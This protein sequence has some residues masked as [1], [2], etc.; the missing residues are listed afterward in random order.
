MSKAEGLYK[1]QLEDWSRTVSQMNEQVNAL[2]VLSSGSSSVS[3]T[4][5]PVSTSTQ[6]MSPRRTQP[7][8][9]SLSAGSGAT[10]TAASPMASRL[11]RSPVATSIP[12]SYPQSPSV[13]SP[14]PSRTMGRPGGMVFQTPHTAGTTSSRLHRPFSTPTTTTGNVTTP[15]KAGVTGNTSPLPTTAGSAAQ[16]NR[17][18]HTRHPPMPTPSPN[19]YSAYKARGTGSTSIHSTA[20]TSTVNGTVGTTRSQFNS[21]HPASI[22]SPYKETP[23][24]TLSQEDQEACNQLL[25]SQTELLEKA[26]KDLKDLENKLKMIQKQQQ[27]K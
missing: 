27:N 11:F 26:E 12:Q 16:F 25:I 6:G 18:Y 15:N 20:G 2:R 1:R 22:T 5:T 21:P 7:P 14:L 10:E 3:T 8:L 19:F 4:S 23:I 9:F 17:Q 13:Q 24:I